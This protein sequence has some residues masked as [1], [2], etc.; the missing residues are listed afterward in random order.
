MAQAQANATN[1]VVSGLVASVNPKGIKLVGHD[2]WLNFSR[3]AEDIVPPSKGEAVTVKLDKAGFIRSI[4]P[5]DNAA[6]QP[7]APSASSAQR[8]RTINRLAI[9]KAAAEF[10]ASKPDAKSTDVLK[11]AEV[12]EAWVLRD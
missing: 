8:E 1:S 5:A 9:L 6:A 10:A 2:E 11:I 12:W 4:A 7:S 3:W